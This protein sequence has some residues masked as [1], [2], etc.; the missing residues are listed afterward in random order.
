MSDQQ[1]F[2]VDDLDRLARRAVDAVLLLVRRGVALA[3][4]VMIVSIVC[5]VGGFLLGLA[6][7]SGGIRT[8][9]IVIGGFFLLVGVGA[10]VTA[11]LRLLAVRRTAGALVAEVR[12]LLAGDRRNERIVVE[13]IE[14]TEGAQHEGV[15]VLSRQFAGMQSAIGDRRAQFKEMA[16]ALR[17]ITTFPALVALSTLV[18]FVFGGLALLFLIALAL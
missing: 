4:G 6:A 13:T 12:G 5:C 14:T 18:S 15:T 9:W 8:V 1:G 2:G 17:A 7:L 3:G 16:A 10:I 11:M